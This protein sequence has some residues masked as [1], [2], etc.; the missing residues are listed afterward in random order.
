MKYLESIISKLSL[1]LIVLSLCYCQSRKSTITNSKNDKPFTFF[2]LGDWGVKGQGN[3]LPVANE[4]IRQSKK[5]KLSLILTVGDNFYEDGVSSINDEHWKLSYKNVYKELTKKYPWYVALGNHDYRGNVEAQLDYHSVNGNWN[6]PGRY[7]TFNKTLSGK[8]KVRFIIIDTDPYIPAYY[9]DPIYKKVIAAQDTAKQTRWIDSVLASSKEEWK[10]VVGHHPLYY[11]N[12]KRPD[13]STLVR[14]M[15]PLFEKHKVQAYI[16]GHV[17]DIE[18]NLL[19]QSRVG[20]IISGS[21]AKSVPSAPKADYTL[22]SSNVPSFTLCTIQNNQ[23]TFKFID[24]TGSTI[25]QNTI[26]KS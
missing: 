14:V 20:H 16:A 8:Q 24:T 19:K 4:M 3:Q 15:E 11:A 21:G 5:N 25:Y 18:Y 10:I 6:M 9:A 7:Y 23:L 2:V 12:A 1:F 26:Q 13:T 17:H 22:F